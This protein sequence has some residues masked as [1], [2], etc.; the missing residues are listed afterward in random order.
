[1][2]HYW[3]K[4]FQLMM[5]LR[6]CLLSVLLFCCSLSYAQGSAK[7]LK[8]D[9][10]E[11]YKKAKYPEAL[12]LFLKYQ[13]LKSTDSETLQKIGIC[14]YYNNEPENAAKQ[15]LYLL[16]TEKSVKPEVYYYLG[17]S[18]QSQKQFKQAIA[19]YKNYLKNIKS[20]HPQRSAVKDIIKRCATGIKLAYASELALVENLGEKV[21]SKGDDFGPVLSPNY[22]GKLYFSSG[23]EGNKGGPRD[24][25]GYSDT[26]FGTHSSD[27][28]STIIINGEWTATAPLESLLN[29]PRH[30]VVLDFNESGQVMYYFKGTDLFSGSMLV[31]SFDAVIPQVHP[32]HF[33]GPMS[34]KRGDTSPYFFNDTTLLFSSDRK[35]GY[36]GKDIYISNFRDGKWAPAKNLGPTINSNYDEITPFLAKDGRTLFFSSNNTNSMGGLDIF[37]ARYDDIKMKWNAPNN[38]GGPINSPNDDTHFRFAQD[39]L[40]AFFA[41]ARNEGFGKRDLYVAYYKSN[42]YEQR[43]ASVPLLFSEVKAY[44]KQQQENGGIVFEN[45]QE[46]VTKPVYPST[47]NFPESE[48]INYEVEALYYKSNDNLL[49]GDNI[50]KLNNVANLMIEYPQL[51]VVLSCNADQSDPAEFDLFFS[52]KRAEEAA[53]YLIDNKVYASNIHLKGLGSNYPIAKNETEGGVNMLGKRF[54]RRIDIQIFNS[55]G[56][57]IKVNVKA[58]N[59]SDFL[60]DERGGNYQRNIKGLSYKVQIASLKQRYKSSLILDYKDAMIEKRQDSGLY[61]YTIGLFQSYDLAENLRKK[62]ERE[63]VSDAFVVPYINGVRA[64]RDDSKIYSAAYPDLLKFLKKTGKE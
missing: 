34:M 6:L 4:K 46:E 3:A 49:N 43:L 42:Q 17:R 13:R 51:K 9:A 22:N 35:G 52:I 56:L 38:L 8:K 32:Y 30:D 15:L 27:I 11:Y 23:R 59:V 20:N 54:N 57:P 64:S 26:R 44:R 7:Q 39:G 16:Q 37:K 41:S 50:Q 61:Q 28:F 14:Y 25:N 10:E 5:Y 31:D 58:P 33:D 40:Q 60:I 48:I 18:F 12:N 62:I 21:N 45:N 63:G 19:Y 24:Q 2:N 29:S 47:P 36:G 53:K 55:A 1:M